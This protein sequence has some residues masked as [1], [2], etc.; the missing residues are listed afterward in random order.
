MAR[1]ELTPE[2]DAMWPNCTVPD[3]GNKACLGLSNEECFPHYLGLRMDDEGNAIFPDEMTE[4]VCK[5]IL[6]NAR[7]RGGQPA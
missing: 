6:E 3:C 2:E 1:Y 4:R 5:R 7:E